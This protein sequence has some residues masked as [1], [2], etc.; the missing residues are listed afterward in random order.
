WNTTVLPSLLCPYMAF[1][2]QTNSG[3]NAMWTPTEVAP[4]TCGTHS[5]WLEVTCVHLKYLDS[6]M[7]YSC[8][9]RPVPEQLVGRGLF[10]CAPVLPKLAIDLNMLEFATG[11]FVN[12]SPNET[13]WVATLT[14]FLD[15]RG[16]IFTTEDSFWRCFGNAL[17]QYQVLM[18]V[19]EA[20]VRKS[21]E[22]ARTLI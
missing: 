2:V 6:I 17:A 18:Q 14:E 12:S 13:A 5:I 7:L 4:C 15:T 11:L 16:Y 3:C 22:I 9:C 8:K 20:E 10:P 21:V 1:R 19:V